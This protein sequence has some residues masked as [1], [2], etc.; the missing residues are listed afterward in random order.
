MSKLKTVDNKES[1][2]QREERILDWWQKNGI[3]KKYMEKN[4]GSDKHFSFIDGPIT[5]NN[6]MGLHHAWG[7]A[8]KDIVSRF[9][10]MK[11]YEQRYQ[12]GFDCQGLW[13]E[14]EVE[15]EFG[16]NSKKDIYD[17]GMGKFTDACKERVNKFSKIQTK[18]SE[19]LGMFM[20][21]ENS[22]YTMSEENNLYIWQFLKECH[23]KGLIYKAK[24]ATTW[25][26]RC[27]T[28]LSQHEQADGYKDIED[29]SVYV[30]FKIVGREN[31]YILAWTTTPW[32]LSSNVLLAINPEFEYVKVKEENNTLYLAKKPAQRLGFKDMEDVDTKELLKMKYESL[33]DFESQKGVDHRVVKWNLV[34]EDSGTGVVHIAPGCGQEDYELGLEVGAPAI[35]PIDESGHFLEGFGSLG[36]KYAHDV[37][38]EVLEYLKSKNLLFKTENYTHSYPHCWRCKTKCLFRLENN[39][40]INITK[41]KDELKKQAQTVEWV[42]DYVGKRMQDWLNNMGDWMISRKRFYGLS[43]PFY[44]CACGQLTIIGNKQELKESAVNP[45]LV[46]KLPSLHRP[47]IDDVEIKCS[48]CGNSVKRITDVGDC[49]LDAGVVGFS[50]LKYNEDRKYW[51]K[52]F[53]ADFITEMIEQVRLWFYSVLVFGVIFE[54]KVPYKTVLGF[55]E[56]RDE[57]NEKMSKTKKNFILFDDSAN[58]VGSDLIRWSFA[59][60]PFGR[61]IR[62]GW[63]PMEETRRRFFLPFWNSYTYFLMYAQMHT[64]ELNEG[65]NPSKLKDPIN[66]WIVN[67][68]HNLINEAN[69]C[70]DGY[71]FIQF[72]EKVEKFVMDLSTWFIRRSRDKF[73]QGEREA[74]DT[75]YYV[76]IQLIK[77]IAPVM[78]FVT[79]DMYQN[80]VVGLGV[81][82]AKESI[83]LEQYPENMNVDEN[84]LREMQIARDVCALG[85]NVRDAQKIKLRQPLSKAYVNIKTKYLQNIIGEELNVKE[86]EYATECKEGDCLY[87][88]TDSGIFVTLD[89][90]MTPELKEEGMYRELIRQIQDLRKKSGLK[91]GQK[92]VM[93]VWSDDNEVVGLFKKLSAQLQ[94]AV[95]AKEVSVRENDGEEI[96]FG[97]YTAK[98]KIEK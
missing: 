41:I 96:K 53:P 75:L 91:V 98:V 22:Y 8:Y 18:Q 95:G 32:T 40:F 62:F 49:W 45:E 72:A 47:W 68:L 82:N 44:E 29:T 80:L 51:E 89:T 55:A 88:Q 33:Y 65:Y 60:C 37:K 85:L 63:K 46:D 81:K 92:V 67:A 56:M 71:N 15:K 28:G 90:K 38:E 93:E 94:T 48:K 31:E 39:W 5:A 52:W 23:K 26:P 20:D 78:P 57:N 2:V 76:L 83:H 10:T 34:D 4:V 6:A 11:G 9:K 35:A 79:E 25:C 77:V 13:V 70:M 17:F 64:W 24:S 12:M 27:E 59:Q 30:R 84:I 7:R 43:L 21:W 1:F 50:T 87:S 66:T 74:L 86:V 19:R 42:P 97:Q 73:K 58:K 69:E 54:G 36:G 14:V 16:F 3:V 61:N